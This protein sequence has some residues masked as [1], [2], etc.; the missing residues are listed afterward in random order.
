MKIEIGFWDYPDKAEKKFIWF[1][2]LSSGCK[3]KF[4]TILNICIS[5]LNKECME[6]GEY[7]A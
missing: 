2:Y 6:E 5:I 4:I 3:C 7:D 1:E